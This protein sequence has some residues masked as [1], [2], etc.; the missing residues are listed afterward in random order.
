MTTSDAYSHG[1]GAAGTGSGG[2]AATGAT[3]QPGSGD[4]AQGVIDQIKEV[5]AGAVA[6]TSEMAG[7]VAD[8]A[9]DQA[10]AQLDNQRQQLAGTITD[11]ASALRQ[12]GQQLRE[13]DQANVA[14]LMDAAAERIDGVGRYLN[15]RRLDDLIGDLERFARREP[16]VFLT[17]AF[18]AGLL[19]ARFLKSGGSSRSSGQDSGR[20]GSYPGMQTY[21]GGTGYGTGRSTGFSYSSDTGYPYRSQTSPSSA[22][23]RPTPAQPQYAGATTAGGAGRTSEHHPN[24]NGG[25]SDWNQGQGG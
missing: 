21:S 15:E 14:Q 10:G 19:A 3:P 6:Q 9:R 2:N 4:G 8:K 22:V 5:G 16:G 7:S 12:T 24:G 23:N 1:P 17:A 13:K 20:R 25:Q 18:G 11:A